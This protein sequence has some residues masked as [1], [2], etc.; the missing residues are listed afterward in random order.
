[1]E[2]KSPVPI[3]YALMINQGRSPIH[4]G[5]K[6]VQA[7]GSVFYKYLNGMSGVET[8]GALAVEKGWDLVYLHVGS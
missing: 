7:M 1:M 2:F 3:L 5:I 8:S 6:D 4:E